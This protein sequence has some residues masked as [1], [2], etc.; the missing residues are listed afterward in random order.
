MNIMY[1]TIR[2][3]PEDLRQTIIDVTKCLRVAIEKSYKFKEGQYYAGMRFNSDKEV[4][5]NL[6][7]KP[8]CKYKGRRD[9]INQL[10]DPKNLAKEVIDTLYNLAFKDYYF[11]YEEGYK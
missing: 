2:D 6:T 11:K 8:Q 9:Y 3:V 10:S 7:L 5:E 4:L 1:Y